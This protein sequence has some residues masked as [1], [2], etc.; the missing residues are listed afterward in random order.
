VKKDLSMITCYK[1]KQMG[2]YADK[3]TEQST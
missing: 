2:H 1:Y 3:C